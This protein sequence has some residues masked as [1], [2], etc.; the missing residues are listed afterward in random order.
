MQRAKRD[1]LN[2]LAQV[3]KTEPAM[4]VMR[5]P[6]RWTGQKL[7]ENGKVLELQLT[8]FPM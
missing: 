2:V 4:K 8:I 1:K 6:G 7:A 3:E 5:L